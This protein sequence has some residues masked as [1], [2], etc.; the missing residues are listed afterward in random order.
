MDLSTQFQKHWK[1]QFP[2]FNTGNCFLILAVSGG[3]DSVVLTDLIAKAGFD[4]SI[5]HCNF[6]LRGADSERDEL[7][8][9]SLIG[10]TEI[11]VKKFDTCTFASDH[12][13]AIQE[14]ARKLRYNWFA[15]LIQAHRDTFIHAN[16]G[17]QLFGKRPLLVTAHHADDNIETVLMNY[18]RGT[19]VL[20]MRGILPFQKERSLIRPLLQFRK[21]DLINYA[22]ENQL[23]FVEDVSNA[24]DKYTRNFF[25]NQLIP[26]VQ[27]VFPSAEENILENIARMRDVAAIYQDSIDAQLKKLLVQK[28]AEIQIPI[29]KLKQQKNLSTILWEIAKQFDFNAAQIAEIIKLM[30]ADNG[31]FLSSQT[32]RIIRNRK[33][34]IIVKHA[35][36]AS[37]HFIIEAG[38]KQL[39]FS[40]G[41][42]KL[43]LLLK[44][45]CKI[46]ASPEFAQ[47]DLKKVQFPLLLRKPRTGDYFYPLGMQKKKKLSRF[48]IDQKLSKT[49]KEACWVLECNKII[50][51]V[52][53]YRIDDRFKLQ[54]NTE[55]V[56]QIQFSPT[57]L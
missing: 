2:D 24:S 45:E 6:Q 41:I 25:R 18:F 16:K 33:W 5:A 14:A 1:D 57:S 38:E 42:L 30:D 35:I 52:L 53:G 36:K 34:L 9:S 21:Q 37:A 27:T 40:D 26:Q 8:V 50:V 49:Q 47:L 54:S 3:V 31:S 20:G 32:H 15:E 44:T 12:K 48:L 11:F 23:V 7:F 46:Y 39:F 55:Q 17:D 13:M 43:E 10:A 51:W 22:S 28:A 19:G 4:F 56:L 29:L